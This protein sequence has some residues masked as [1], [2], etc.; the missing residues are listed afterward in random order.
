MQAV[1]VAVASLACSMGDGGAQTHDTPVPP[2]TM[3][4]MIG[5][6]FDVRWAE[7]DNDMLE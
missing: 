7:F 5:K 6:G 1:L 2:E 3:Q 4:K